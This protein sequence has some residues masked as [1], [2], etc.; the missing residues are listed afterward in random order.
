MLGVMSTCFIGA[1]L[2]W[3]MRIEAP[4]SWFRRD[5]A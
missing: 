2:V 5:V 1:D 3:D 4:Q